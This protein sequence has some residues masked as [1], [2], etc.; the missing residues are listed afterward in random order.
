MFNNRVNDKYLMKYD[1]LDLQ[2]Y[3]DSNTKVAIGKFLDELK[4]EIKTISGNFLN[5]S[6]SNKPVISL[7]VDE[8]SHE[9][10]LKKGIFIR[11]S[12]TVDNIIITITNPGMI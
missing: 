4:K 7:E 5:S 6:L 10:S 1:N 11:E 12:E 8:I 3:F 9:F 2:S